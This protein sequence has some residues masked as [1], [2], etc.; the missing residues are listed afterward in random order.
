MW[1]VFSAEARGKAT[2][3]WIIHAH[4]I[5]WLLKY[6]WIPTSKYDKH[7]SDLLF[8]FYLY[9]SRN[10]YFWHIE[11]LC[12]TDLILVTICSSTPSDSSF[13]NGVMTPACNPVYRVLIEKGYEFDDI[14]VYLVKNFPI[15]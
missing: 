2:L 9:T 3:F 6:R 13:W 10:W 7:K 1:T 8:Y 15:Q 11:G 5:S 14:L 12:F 4:I